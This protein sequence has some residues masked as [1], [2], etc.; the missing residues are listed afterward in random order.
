MLYILYT[1]LFLLIYKYC[2]RKQNIDDI[3]IFILVKSHIRKTLLILLQE[4]YQKQY[5]NSILEKQSLDRKINRMSKAITFSLRR[6]VRQDQIIANLK[7]SNDDLSK[8]ETIFVFPDTLLQKRNISYH[9]FLIEMVDEI[10]GKGKHQK[11]SDSQ[12]KLYLEN[13]FHTSSSCSSST[14]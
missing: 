3:E 7:K 4:A 2:F 8:E 10:H 9:R 13:L 1:I 5:H 12:S 14:E 6:F 11:M